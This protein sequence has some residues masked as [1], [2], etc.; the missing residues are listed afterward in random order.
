MPTSTDGKHIQY[1]PTL[2]FILLVSCS[3]FQ[4]LPRASCPYVYCTNCM[5]FL[6]LQKVK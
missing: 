3:F 1:A 4:L 5:Q 6:V 2:L